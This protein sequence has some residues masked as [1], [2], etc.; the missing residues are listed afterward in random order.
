MRP[1]PSP[2]LRRS[3]TTGSL[4]PWLAGTLTL[5]VT[6]VPASVA[7]GCASPAPPAAPSPVQ[8]EEVRGAPIELPDSPLLEE[9]ADLEDR[10]TTGGGRLLELLSDADDRV[11]GRAAQALGRLPFPEFGD[12][13]TDGLCRALEDA[14]GEVRGKALFGLGL[15][16]DPR[17]SGVLAA[18]R[19]DPDPE[20]RARVVEAAS[21]IDDPALHAE[22]L[23]ALRDGDLKVRVQAAL[24]TARWDRERGDAELVDR[25]L[26]D[27]LRPYLMNSRRPRTREVETE[28]AWRILYALA[29]RRSAMGRGAFLEYSASADPLERLFAVQGLAFVPF[30]EEVVD[31]LVLALKDANA[32]AEPDWRVSYEATKALAQQADARA[33]APLLA[34]SESE[35]PHVRAAVFEALGRFP[36]EKKLVVPALRRG[37][38]DVSTSVRV[39]ALRSMAVAFEPSDALQTLERFAREEDPVLRAGAAEAAGELRDERIVPLLVRLTRDGDLRVATSAVLAL[40]D[41][42]DPG[43]RATLHGL[44]S[45]PDNGLRLSAVVA[46]RRRPE[47]ADVAPLVGA[48]QGSRG[49][50]STEIAFNVLENLA[51]IGGPAAEQEL[52]KALDD[53]RPHV[54]R[55][56]RRALNASF[57]KN[58][59]ATQPPPAEPES[60]APRA[61]KD[62]PRWR[63]DPLVEIT[64]TQGT[65][66]FELFPAEAPGHV[67]NFLQLAEKGAYRDLAFHR[68]VPDFVVQGGDYRGDGNGARPWRGEALRHEFGPRPFVRGSLG[69]PRNEDPDSGGSQFFITHRPTPH[70]DGRY[71]IFGELR[72]GGDVLDRIEVGDRILAVRLLK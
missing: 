47:A 49:D 26:L 63:Y 61:G 20:V 67:H 71:T 48:L 10:R 40:E 14:S 45:H 22:L 43:V 11:R 66:V 7:P 44:L 70:L 28:L 37:L 16:A 41:R 52:T 57:G 30:D 68:V 2:Q 69:M 36:A 6:V 25:A 58:L 18:Y 24:A 34:A 1:N 23:V 9:I 19:N 56:A 5:L 17:S 27:A 8:R 4:P 59:P 64:T 46:L 38:L 62:F 72:S 55:V 42:D 3:S 54:R 15:R 53:P 13:V 32:L 35:N 60:G 29:R 33:I 12:E 39:A 50:I 21:R 51:A 65:L 31:A